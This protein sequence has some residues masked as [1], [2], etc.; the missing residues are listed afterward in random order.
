MPDLLEKVTALIVRP[1]GEGHDLLLFEHPFAGIQ[2]PAGTVEPGETPAAAVI[3]ETLEETGLVH[4]AIRQE[5][6]ATDT[7]LPEPLRVISTATAV[8]GEPEASGGRL[9]QLSRGL[10]VRHE[11]SAGALARVVYEEWNWRVDPPYL[12][13]RIAGW[14][15]QETLARALRRHYF[16]LLAE[17]W[18][19]ERWTVHTDGHDFRLF[20]APLDGLP[21]IRAS[22]AGWLAMLPAGYPYAFRR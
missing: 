1:S 21:P 14:V 12:R 6:G 19:S 10:T 13:S 5:L 8:Y 20:W 15:P 18:P 7:V 4:V 11:R 9:G 2:I 22:Q 16:L 3:R 17:A